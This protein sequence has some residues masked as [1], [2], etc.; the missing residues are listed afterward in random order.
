M[1]RDIWRREGGGRGALARARGN[2]PAPSPPRSPHPD[3][4]GQG[5][6]VGHLFH[7][8]QEAAAARGAARTGLGQLLEYEGGETRVHVERARHAHAGHEAG[9]DDV[10]GG[11]HL[12]DESGLLR[13]GRGVEG[14]RRARR[15][16]MAS[17]HAP[18]APPPGCGERWALSWRRASGGAGRRGRAER[19]VGRCRRSLFAHTPHRGPPPLAARPDV[20]SAPTA[21]R[22]RAAGVHSWRRARVGPAPAPAP[23]PAA[24]PPG[25]QLRVAHRA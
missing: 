22:R 19:D 18:V 7:S 12:V 15:Q 14:R 10:L 17:P 23:R 9:A 5:G 1:A 24:P 6:H 20:C 8:G 21:G 16:R 3:Y 11:G 4:A 13:R 2:T 25:S